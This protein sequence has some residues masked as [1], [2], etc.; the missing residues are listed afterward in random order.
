MTGSVVL[1]LR[2]H[3]SLM[4]RQRQ[5]FRGSFFPDPGQVLRELLFVFKI[6]LTRDLDTLGLRRAGPMHGLGKVTDRIPPERHVF[7]Q[8]QYT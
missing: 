7:Y 6:G 3:R 5:V 8:A 1:T 2:E 4:R